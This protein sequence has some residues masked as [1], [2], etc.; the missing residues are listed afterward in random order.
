VNKTDQSN[1]DRRGFLKTAAVT[2]GITMV[3]ARSVADTEAN[4]AIELGLI[5]VGK[6][7]LM[8]SKAFN[9]NGGYKFVALADP[10]SMQ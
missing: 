9:N 4:S 7:G 3:K 2:A 6:R 8:I 1:I 5:G 10:R